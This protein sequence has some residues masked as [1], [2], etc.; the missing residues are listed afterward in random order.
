MTYLVSWSWSVRVPHLPRAADRRRHG[1]VDDDVARHVQVGDAAARVDLR[2]RRAG[3]VR[4][5]DRLLDLRPLV[6]RAAS[7]RS[8]Q[9]AAE[10]LVGVGADRR[11][12]VGVPLEDVREVGPHDVAEDDRVGDLHH[13]GLEVHRE[14]DALLLGLRDLRGEEGLQRGA[15]HARRRRRSRRPSTSQP[16][17]EDGRRAVGARRARSAGWSRASHRHRRLG[18]P[19]VALAHRRDVRAGVR[20]PGAHRVRVLLGVRSSPTRARGGRSCPRAAPG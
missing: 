18:V 17:L 11:E 13:R 5:R 7:A 20:R 9:H 1:G 16:V 15:A 19:E 3:R 14:Q 12:V 2:E 8:R 4:R 10:A 6:L